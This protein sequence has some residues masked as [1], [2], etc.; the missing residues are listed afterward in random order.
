ML[1]ASQL[2]RYISIIIIWLTRYLSER[3]K[4]RASDKTVETVER[5]SMLV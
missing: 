3:E 4:E 1:Y 5:K 2:Y